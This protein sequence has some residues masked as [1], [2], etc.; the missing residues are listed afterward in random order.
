MTFRGACLS[1]EQLPVG[2]GTV[3]VAA[4]P[5]PVYGGGIPIVPGVPTVGL[6]T[7]E[8]SDGF[9]LGSSGITDVSGTLTKPCCLRAG[10]CRGVSQVAALD[11]RVD[12]V[13]VLGRSTRSSGAMFTLVG[14]SFALVG[15]LLTLIGDPVALIRSLLAFCQLTLTILETSR[16]RVLRVRVE[17]SA[18]SR[19]SRVPRPR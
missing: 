16:H 9:P 7:G 18:T 5:D 3:T 10:C 15:R 13:L 14:Q 1:G 4:L 19:R 8:V 17:H 6:G 2:G 12:D 11:G